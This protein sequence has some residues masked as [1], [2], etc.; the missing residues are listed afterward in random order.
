MFRDHGGVAP[1]LLLILLLSTVAG[2]SGCASSDSSEPRVKRKTSMPDGP[3]VWAGF[4]KTD[5]LEVIA[6]EDRTGMDTV[7][8]F[9][10]R[11]SRADVDRALVAAALRPTME[12]DFTQPETPLTDDLPQVTSLPVFKSADLSDRRWASDRWE[13]P[14]GTTVIYRTYI[15]GVLP[16]GDE[17]IEVTANTS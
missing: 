1:R 10:L 8:Q 7:V 2:V 4:V 17:L 11:G 14:D 5:G 6:V 16:S 3:I 15:R 12:A 13:S 9:V